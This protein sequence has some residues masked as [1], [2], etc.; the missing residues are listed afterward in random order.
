MDTKNDQVPKGQKG[1]AACGAAENVKPA[2]MRLFQ[3]VKEKTD[4]ENSEQ[5]PQKHLLD[6]FAGSQEMVVY[7]KG[8]GTQVNDADGQKEGCYI[9]VFVKR[10]QPHP[11][12][13][14]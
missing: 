7:M 11:A 5:T 9:Q 8:P 10:I 3:Q 1:K 14:A 13:S 12:E 4:A 2:Q 6:D